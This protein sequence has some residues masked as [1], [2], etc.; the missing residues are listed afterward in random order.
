M[1]TGTRDSKKQAAI[2]GAGVLSP[3]GYGRKVFFQ[4]LLEGRDGLRPVTGFE[5]H[6]L[7]LPRAGELNGDGPE[8][9][10]EGRSLRPLDRTAR[11]AAAAVELALEDSGFRSRTAA[12]D[13]GASAG[14][15]LGTM[16][17]SVRTISE[18]DRRALTAGPR[19]TKPFDFANSVIN[20]AAGQAAIWHGLSGVNATV[21]GGTTAGVAAL[22][23]GADL[24]RTGRV[25][26]L[27]AGGAE[28]LCFESCWGFARAG[29][30]AADPGGAT[31]AAGVPFHAR[32][33]GFLPGEG[34]ALLMLEE[35]ESARR[36]SVPILGV[37]TGSGSS[38]DPS[39][40]S[41]AEAS[42]A[43]V[44]R[45][46]TAALRD[47][48]REPEDIDCLS[49]SAS[50]GVH[51]DAAEARGL[52]AALGDRV[53]ALPVTAIKGA[54]GESLGAAGAF[55]T[56]T[57]LEA[58]AAGELP[59]IRGLDEPEP[60]LPLRLAGTASRQGDF[61]CGLVTALSWDGHAW[62]LVV[63]AV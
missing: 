45:A 14:L 50:G 52:A 60:D 5:T 57:L 58:F 22:A 23:H 39:R 16:Y 53:A 33:H 12:S 25:G 20:A 54:I 59:G 36:Q 38:F 11:L 6:Q 31:Q 62:A 4:A 56:L 10:L 28:E 19:Y 51:V 2:T 48:G 8:Q 26:A 34:A 43:A 30:L 41:D 3:L 13:E 61:H 24:I 63:E 9:F 7:S 35:A 17:G 29:L 42:A 55:Q 40:G 27:A 18:F 37:L 47:A 15:V 1:S 32:R 49:V 44:R 21:A 46:I